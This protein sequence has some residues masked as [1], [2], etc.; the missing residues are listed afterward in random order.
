MSKQTV[1]CHVDMSNTSEF[2]YAHVDLS[3]VQ[4]GPG[5]QV[6]VH[7]PIVDI[8]FG[9]V[10]SYDRTATVSKAGLFSRLWV[11]LTARLEVTMLYEVSFSTT[12]FTKT[13]KYPRQMPS[14]EAV[15]LI[16]NEG[17]KV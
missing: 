16:L 15:T 4:V 7:D 6:L 9:E 13:K 5:D 17:V 1:P 2:L 10:L 11:Y 14:K 3:G 8:N 12:R